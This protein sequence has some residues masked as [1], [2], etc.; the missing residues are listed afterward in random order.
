[1]IQ[2]LVLSALLNMDIIYAIY[3]CKGISECSWCFNLV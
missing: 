1:M 2:L 3:Y